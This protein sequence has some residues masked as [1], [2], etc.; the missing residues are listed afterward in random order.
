MTWRANF[1]QEACQG[2][3]QGGDLGCE[4]A[5]GELSG[6]LAGVGLRRLAGPC[7]R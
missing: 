4:L 6:E 3:F 5:G 1:W 7:T 2:G